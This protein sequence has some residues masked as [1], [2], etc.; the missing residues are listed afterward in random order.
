MITWNR[1]VPVDTRC[2]FN[3][4]TTSPTLYR[5]L[6]D[7]ETT[8]YVYWDAMIHAINPITEI[9]KKIGKINYSLTI[10]ANSSILDDLHRSEYPS[11][12]T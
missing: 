3:V 9:D 2:R 11:V 12:H 5:R 10:L 8:S 7:V 4:Y 6:I 1:F